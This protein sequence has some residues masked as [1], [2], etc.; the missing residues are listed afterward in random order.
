[1]CTHV[2]VFDENHLAAREDPSNP[3]P[4]EFF[5]GNFSEYRAYKDKSAKKLM[6]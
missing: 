2:L 3:C 6:S 1:V 4:V 5:N